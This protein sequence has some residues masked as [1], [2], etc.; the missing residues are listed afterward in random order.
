[1]K[2][3]FLKLFL[4][5]LTAVFFNCKSHESIDSLMQYKV[6]KGKFNGNVLVLKN[7]E[8]IYEKSFGYADAS[9][10]TKLTNQFRFDLGSVYKE[11][12]AVSIMQLQEKG[13]LQ[14]D[15]KISLYLKY[16]P[17]W[18]SKIEIKHLL[19]YT[20]GLP[21]IQWD[22][23]FEKSSTITDE[24]IKQDLMNLKELEFKP[25]S[26]YLYTNYSPILLGQIV[27][28]ITKQTFSEYVKENLF[29]PFGLKNAKIHSQVPYIDRSFMAIPFDKNFKED[30]YKVKLSGAIFSFTA[31]DIESWI[32]N[33]H[34]YKVINKESLKFL[35]QE[36][37]FWGNIQS[38]LGNVKWG[39]DMIKEHWHHGEAGNYE[40]IVKRIYEGKDVF[41]IIVQANQK[42]KNVI[43]ISDDIYDILRKIKKSA[44]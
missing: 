32:V 20:S 36:A 8:T 2:K 1:M 15:D 31:R 44:L 10:I 39:N 30:P 11:F 33:L 23:Y 17:N 40:C 25:G 21:K 37:D 12:P 28:T 13:L 34:A 9:K 29:I 27:E 26:D 43:D 35:S 22:K 4:V 38:S 7:G 19:Q 42:R 6:Q 24:K 41:T 14:T 5:T 16:L 3:T 18:A